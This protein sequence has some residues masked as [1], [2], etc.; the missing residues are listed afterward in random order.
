[1]RAVIIDCAVYR[2]GKRVRL[3]DETE[4]PDESWTAKVMTMSPKEATERAR[5]A[6]GKEEGGFVWV[7][8]HNPTVDEMT[9]VAA[10][11]HLHPLAVEDALVAHQRPKLER[12][13][14][15][16]VF[17]VLK[18]LWYVD[19]NDAV[20]T[21][22]ISIFVGPDFVV[23]VR[24]GEGGELGI[25]RRDLED[26]Q[27]VLGHGPFAVLYSVCD[28][29]VDDY[30]L[31]AEELQMDVDEIELSVFSEERTSDAQRIYTLKRELA[32][33]RRAVAPLR[34]PI[35]RLARSEIP[36]MNPKAATFFR[37]CP[38]PRS[39]S[40]PTRSRRSTTCCPARTTPIWPGSRCSRTTT[41]AR[42]R[43]G[44]PWPRF[45]PCSPAST[46]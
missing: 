31:V 26:Q 17:M 24:H 6:A 22:E 7:G 41:C 33:F 36:E 11:F 46:A 10:V 3:P 21:G 16:H 20:E 29:V 5:E 37:D 30:E 1:M 38:R 25:R 9:S 2:H 43:P 27:T 8:L 39:S 14:G 45:R 42:S 19:A 13:P 35:N 18:T 32:E 28:K 4:A 12:Y 23:T 34:E 15:A 44:W 40:W